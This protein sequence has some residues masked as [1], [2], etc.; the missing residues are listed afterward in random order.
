MNSAFHV[1]RDGGNE[2][3]DDSPAAGRRR[4]RGA[5]DSQKVSTQASRNSTLM[6]PSSAKRGTRRWASR[7]AKLENP[8]CSHPRREYSLTTADKGSVR[9]ARLARIRL[10]QT[11][12]PYDAV[13]TGQGYGSVWKTRNIG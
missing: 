11:Q 6:T 2:K 8:A 7:Y 10:L 1:R 5:V 13:L 9:E 3:N 4:R 12:K